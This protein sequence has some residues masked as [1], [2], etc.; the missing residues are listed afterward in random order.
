MGRAGKLLDQL[1]GEI[2]LTRRTVLHRERAQV[3][4]AGQ[5][6]PAAG[7]DRG[8]PGPPRAA[9]RADRAARDLHARQLRHQAALGAA[10]RASPGCAAFRRRTSSAAGPCS[11]TRSSIRPP[12]CARPRCSSSSRGLPGA[13]A[14]ARSERPVRGRPAR[15]R[16]RAGPPNRPPSPSPAGAG[17]RRRGRGRT[18]S[19]SS[20]ARPVTRLGAAWRRRRRSRATRR[21]RP[22]APREALAERCAPATWCSSRATS[23]RARPPSCAERAVRSACPIASPAPRSRSAGST[24]AGA[25]SH[26]DLFRLESLAGEDPGLL[27]DYLDARHDRV[28]GVARARR[29]RGAR[30]RARGAESCASSIWGERPAASRRGGR[31]RS[32][33][34]CGAARRRRR[35]DPRLRHLDG[36][37]RP[38]ACSGRRRAF[39]TPAARPERLLGPPEH[40]AELL[41]VLAALLEEAGTRLAGR[42]RDRGR[43]GAGNFHG[44]ADRR[45]DGARPRHRRSASGCSPVSSLAALAAGLAERR[46]GGTP[47]AAA[48]RRARGQVFAALYRADEPPAS[49]VGA[50]RAWARASCSTAL[51]D[52]TGTPWRRRLGARITR[53]PR[54]GGVMSRRR[55]PGF[56]P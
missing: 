3:P 27:D 49:R 4:A 5:P 18:S 50:A 19:G 6:R 39:A 16:A 17:G 30:P 47:A 11:S 44:P 42:R 48:D 15:R 33:T 36:G 2:G 25:V 51:A 21:R 31:D 32:S 14:A 35:D 10:P 12:P 37:H 54:G 40:S 22:S 43:R 46:A 45:R 52:S 26:I 7:R 8:L 20:R 23:A 24:R 29:C 55:T 28:R 9:D 41:P 38:P 53:G 1:L 34:R 13:A 56:T